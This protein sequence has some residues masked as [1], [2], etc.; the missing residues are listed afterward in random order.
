MGLLNTSRL[1]VVL[2]AC[3]SLCL[4]TPPVAA[5]DTT[6]AVRV[7]DPTLAATLRDASL[8]SRTLRALVDELERSDVIVHV[9]AME[10]RADQLG[11]RLAF[12][13]AASG[14][15]ILRIAIN[16]RLPP[17]RRA[18]LLG[19]E[20]QHAVE[21]A[22]APS[23]V[24][25]ASFAELYRHIGYRV[26]NISPSVCYETHAAQQIAD[27]VTF[28]LEHSARSTGRLGAQ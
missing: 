4:F 17:A 9:V 27:R 7:I 19:H 20:L 3:L 10:P 1:L 21:V 11:G 25:V 8:S 6:H 12:V 23:V 24:D 5:A 15:R 13:H 28:D 22:Q 16:P 26:P 14:V 18:A 2:F